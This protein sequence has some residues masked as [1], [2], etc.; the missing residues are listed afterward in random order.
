MEEKSDIGIT[1]SQGDFCQDHRTGRSIRA[2]QHIPSIIAKLILQRKAASVKTTTRS[3]Q[4]NYKVLCRV[5]LLALKGSGPF[6]RRLPFVSESV[7]EGEKRRQTPPTCWPLA[8]HQGSRNVAR[9][10]R[11]SVSAMVVALVSIFAWPRA[12]TQNNE[13]CAWSRTR[14]R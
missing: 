3:P 1:F 11:T 8:S 5:P 13:S 12:P 2:Q 10:W 9:R 7:N 4:E 14:T 6:F